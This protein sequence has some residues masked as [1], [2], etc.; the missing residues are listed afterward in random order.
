MARRLEL[1]LYVVTIAPYYPL[2]PNLSDPIGYLS[3]AKVILKR[4]LNSISGCS[5]KAFRPD[6]SERI[7]VVSAVY[8]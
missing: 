8:E 5:C 7:C 6:G 4:L 2:S 3:M 1:L